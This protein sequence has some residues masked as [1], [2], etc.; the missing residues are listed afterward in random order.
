[1]DASSP[2]GSG[3]ASTLPH[4]GRAVRRSWP[5]DVRGSGDGPAPGGADEPGPRFRALPRA[6]A[7]R[8]RTVR[9]GSA[10]RAHARIGPGGLR[11]FGYERGGARRGRPR[12]RPRRR[13]AGDDPAGVRGAL[14]GA[15]RGGRL[16]GRRALPGGVDGATPNR[17]VGAGGGA[18]AVAGQRQP[19]ART[20]AGAVRR[21]AACVARADPRAAVPAGGWPARAAGPRSPTGC[22]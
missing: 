1:M 14:P 22:R 6:G 18:A 20:P 19:G 11:A 17:A 15:G 12:E 2:R 5:S 8:Q 4:R 16:G 3:G 21:C 9:S 10:A 13:G 7:R